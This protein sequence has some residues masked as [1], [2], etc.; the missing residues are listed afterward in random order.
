[1]ERGRG[2]NQ[3]ATLG[4]E[5]RLFAGSGMPLNISRSAGGTLKAHIVIRLDCVD[6]RYA[7]RSNHTRPNSC[8][9]PQIGRYD[10]RSWSGEEC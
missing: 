5:A 2:G 1:M 3:I 8:A 6:T 9:G 7:P 10:V 4:R